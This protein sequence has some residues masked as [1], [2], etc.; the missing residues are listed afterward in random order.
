MRDE[1]A[2]VDRAGI[3]AVRDA[4]TSLLSELA[5][6]HPDALA[7]LTSVTTLARHGWW[8]RFSYGS[9]NDESAGTVV[10]LEDVP[11]NYELIR[12]I[13]EESL[14]WLGVTELSGDLRFVRLSPRGR[15]I[16]LGEDD[17]SPS[18]DSKPVESMS[19][20]VVSQFSV[21]PNLEV[22]APPNLSASVL[23]RLF[24]VTEPSD[25]GMMKLNRDSI[26]RALDRGESTH[27]LLQF[28]KEHSRTG[29]PQN[30]QYMFNEIG[31]RH[32]HVRIG[33]AGLYLQV[34]DPALLQEIKSERGLKIRFRRELGDTI[35]LI[36]GDSVDA[37][38]KQLRQA[39]Y[40]PV[41]DEDK[42][43]DP[44]EDEGQVYRQEWSSSALDESIP[45]IE[46]D[47]R[48][49]WDAIARMDGIDLPAHVVEPKADR[50][51][52]VENVIGL[53]DEAI[54]DR[55][56]VEIRYEKP[57][58][59]T[60]TTRVIEPVLRS[61]WLVNGYCRLRQSERV[62]NTRYIRWAQVTG[63]TF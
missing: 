49:D 18:Q 10:D 63:E 57:D 12:R 16:L 48:I 55:S 2:Y 43:P 4:A 58:T 47:G 25:S 56:C 5:K 40:F 6:E 29:I 60:G 9:R 38:L 21:Q 3:T 34:S 28:L 24:R 39:G 35:A 27:G 51:I 41:A 13:C 8:R 22:Y 53:L 44:E 42:T 15:R 45:S 36:T 30:V 54:R 20:E 33:Q 14:F 32:G 11:S 46:V 61:D 19:S 50:V 62:F 59:F 26:R 1:R 37:V 31:G 23:H 17:R 52:G 7:S